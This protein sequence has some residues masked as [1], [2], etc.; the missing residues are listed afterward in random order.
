MTHSEIVGTL[1]AKAIADRIG[2]PAGRVRVWKARKVIPRSA[3]AELID[4]F[5][6]VTLE[7][8]KAGEA[9]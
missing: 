4:A 9:G 6:T 1:G 5:P 2:V 7:L 8:L 3:W